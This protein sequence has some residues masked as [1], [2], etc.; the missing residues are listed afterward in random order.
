[1]S[2]ER[3]QERKFFNGKMM[4][5]IKVS[6]EELSSSKKEIFKKI[7]EEKNFFVNKL[8]EN[9]IIFLA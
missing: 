4:V 2:I 8:L 3:L 5:M 9:E 7:T 1:M 6:K